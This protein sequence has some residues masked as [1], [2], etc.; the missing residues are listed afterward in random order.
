FFLYIPFNAP[1]TPVQDPDAD[2]NGPVPIAARSDRKAYGK[3]LER[4][5]KGGGDVL[6]TLDRMK[7]ADNT[8]VVF[9]NDNGGD[10]NGKLRGKIGEAWEGGIRVA[11]MARWPGV[12]PA[13]KVSSQVGIGMDW[14]PTLAA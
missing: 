5:E 12:I 10:T 3:A 2:P 7:V 1:A 9:M 14:L 8:L 4:M 6:A 13:G 11:C